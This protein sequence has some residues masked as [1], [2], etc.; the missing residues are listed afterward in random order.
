MSE[1]T[2][3]PRACVDDLRVQTAVRA[4]RLLHALGEDE[5][6]V[7][8]TLIAA[9][10]TG[11]TSSLCECPIARYLM[12]GGLGL[13]HVSVKG[14]QIFLSF[15][16]TPGDWVVINAPWAVTQFVD[17][18]DEGR[19]PKLRD[20]FHVVTA[21]VMDDLTRKVLARFAEELGAADDLQLIHLAQRAEARYASN[22]GERMRELVD[23]ERSRRVFTAAIVGAR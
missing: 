3:T 22:L 16:A 4:L 2:M 19:Y 21:A 18:F 9:A 13:H 8:E 12:R 23:A 20:H 17:G 14:S 11:L 5:T 1:Q 15:S 10:V 7:A 6:T